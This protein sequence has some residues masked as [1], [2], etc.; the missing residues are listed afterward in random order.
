MNINST[1]RTNVVIVHIVV[2][3]PVYINDIAYIQDDYRYYGDYEIIYILKTKLG[4]HLSKEKLNEIIKIIIPKKCNSDFCPP[5]G[6]LKLPGDLLNPDIIKLSLS[7][8]IYRNQGY[9][10]F[11]LGN[12]IYCSL[13]CP[14]SKHDTPPRDVLEEYN[15]SEKCFY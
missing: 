15:A 5:M 12:Y 7:G 11:N 9:I 2:V 13:Q 8:T 1:F 3:I 14:C 10:S 6:H 4:T